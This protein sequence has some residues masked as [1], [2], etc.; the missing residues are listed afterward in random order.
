VPA[1]VGY[2]DASYVVA[3]GGVH[4]GLLGGAWWAVFSED[5][6]DRHLGFRQRLRLP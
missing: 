2:A 5:A 1:Q 4:R 6:A 3:D